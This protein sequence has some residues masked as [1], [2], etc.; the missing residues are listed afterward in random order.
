M[1]KRKTTPRKQTSRPQ[2]QGY[3]ITLEGTEGSGKST[4]IKNLVSRLA[5]LGR[6]IV[7]TREPG[8]TENAE[9][10][11][12]VVLK[13]KV[14]P[15]AELLLYEASRAEHVGRLILPKLQA[16]AIVICDRFTDSTLAYQGTAR[17][18]DWKMITKLNS[19]ATHGLTPNLTFFLDLDPRTGLERATDRNRF[20]EE[21]VRFQA[22]VRKGLERAMKENKKRVVRID[23]NRKSPDQ[24]AEIAIKEIN[25]RLQKIKSRST[26]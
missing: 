8:G 18:L 10:I 1:K 7:V 19:V 3:F 21:G 11:R 14:D 5:S 4:L 23:V 24:V 13:N 25:S 20:E 2:H 12:E 17:G 26:R 16:G 6:E 15:L 9:R 22:L